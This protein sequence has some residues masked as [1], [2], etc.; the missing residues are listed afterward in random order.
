MEKGK[1][2]KQ[3]DR[4][5]KLKL[6]LVKE[7]YEKLRKVIPVL[8][9]WFTHHSVRWPSQSCRSAEYIAHFFSIYI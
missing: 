9:D 6:L 3:A 5:R 2:A 7:H 8:Y 1:L 4:S